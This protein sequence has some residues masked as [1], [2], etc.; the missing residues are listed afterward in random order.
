MKKN[1]KSELS[2][3]AKVEY[4]KTKAGAK[5][6]A[7]EL[8]E[9]KICSEPFVKAIMVRELKSINNHLMSELKRLKVDL[10]KEISRK[11]PVI[12]FW[13]FFKKTEI[14]IDLES[15]IEEMEY[16]IKIVESYINKYER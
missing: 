2:Y 16:S 5:E 14:E 15:R 9:N 7:Q 12:F 1:K 4:D 13:T 3:F 8:L 10:S 11:V 6:Y